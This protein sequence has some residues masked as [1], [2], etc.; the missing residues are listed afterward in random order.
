PIWG[1]KMGDEIV[2]AGISR[3]DGSAADG[4][5]L[6]RTPPRGSGYSVGGFDIQRRKAERTK[7]NCYTLSQAELAQL[8]AQ[9]ELRIPFARIGVRRSACPTALVQP[10]SAVKDRVSRSVDFAGLP[11]GRAKNPF[12]IDD[13]AF[14]ALD[15]NGNPARAAEIVAVEKDRG[16]RIASRL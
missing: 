9:F 16:L 4:I 11:I 15:R 13:I 2:L 5:H 12:S 3:R 14:Q 6:L 1:M 10:P 7:L 8:H